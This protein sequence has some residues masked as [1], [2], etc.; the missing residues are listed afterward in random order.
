[1]RRVC[2]S[3]PWDNVKGLRE[4]EDRGVDTPVW[5][6]VPYIFLGEIANSVQ[7]E[8]HCMGNV[9]EN[10][11]SFSDCGQISRDHTSD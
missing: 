2:S 1:M 8:G 6:P 9:S 10:V 7:K 3:E 4:E 5:G 11:N